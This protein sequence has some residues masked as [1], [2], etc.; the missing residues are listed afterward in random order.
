MSPCAVPHQNP[1]NAGRMKREIFSLLREHRD[2]RASISSS[3]ISGPY[4]IGHAFNAILYT[5]KEN[6]RSFNRC[7]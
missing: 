1:V 5:R 6:K 2:L 7:N 4:E 3:S